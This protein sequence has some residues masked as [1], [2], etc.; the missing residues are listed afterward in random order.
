[1]PGMGR[2]SDRPGGPYT[3]DG[4]A[5]FVD[6]VL[7][8]LDVERAHMVL[9]DFGGPWGVQWAMRHPDRLASAVLIDTGVLIGYLGNPSALEW[10]TPLVG[11]VSMATTT[12]Q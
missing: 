9:H 11:E 5:H 8:A 2:A 10:H 1:M 7:R 4:A 12:R 6:G 3:T